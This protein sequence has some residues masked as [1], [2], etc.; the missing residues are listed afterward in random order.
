[1]CLLFDRPKHLLKKVRQ[2]KAQILIF[3]ELKKNK[4][5][6]CPIFGS[7]LLSLPLYEISSL[8]LHT[9]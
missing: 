2:I 5:K 6:N 4:I 8:F 3:T 9:R 7:N 1:M